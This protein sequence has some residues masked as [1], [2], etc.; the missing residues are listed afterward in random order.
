MKLYEVNASKTDESNKDSLYSTASKNCEVRSDEMF[1][2]VR[3]LRKRSREGNK[4]AVSNVWEV[5]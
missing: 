5:S 4:Q 2:G 3:E 1:H